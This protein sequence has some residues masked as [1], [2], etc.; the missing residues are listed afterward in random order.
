MELTQ[1]AQ[2][3]LPVV[4]LDSKTIG[5]KDLQKMSAKYL[6][7]LAQSGPEIIVV[8]GVKRAVL[9]DYDQ[10]SHMQKRFREVVSEL[11]TIGQFLPRF[12]VP[13]GY[14][15]KVA[16]LKVELKATLQK[17]VSESPETSPFADLMD[18]IMAVA[19]GV[20]AES[21]PPPAEMKQNVK[22]KLTSSQKEVETV[23][24]RP[25]GNFAE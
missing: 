25:K 18:S 12:Q 14:E 24:A 10:F 8:N 15:V 23:S 4:T 6:D 7:G 22:N 11:M 20:F 13:A 17:I 16:K 21:T 19:F 1:K 2:E 3:K 9:V 5:T